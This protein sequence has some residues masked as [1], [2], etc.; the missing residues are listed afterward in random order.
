MSTSTSG[1]AVLREAL[2]VDQVGGVANTGA[3]GARPA[4]EHAPGQFVALF[5]SLAE[6][7]GI[8]F[9]QVSAGKGAQQG[10]PLRATGEQ[11]ASVCS[12]IGA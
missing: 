5:G 7:P 1:R 2:R 12:H 11:L 4:F 3:Q 8:D 10:A 9:L 6:H